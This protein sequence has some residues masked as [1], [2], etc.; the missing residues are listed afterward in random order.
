MINSEVIFDLTYLRSISNNDQA[1]INDMIRTFIQDTPTYMED[2]SRYFMQ[3]D[4]LRLYK[5][6]HKFAPTLIFVGANEKNDKLDILE[7]YAREEKQPVEISN[8]ISE[9]TD[10]C[11]TLIDQLKLILNNSEN[12]DTRL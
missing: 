4:Y 5:T 1:F 3:K 7:N 12:E 11:N 2:M 9:I 6:V 8:L 10:Y